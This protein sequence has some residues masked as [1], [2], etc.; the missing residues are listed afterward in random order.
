MNAQ[1]QLYLEI[2]EKLHDGTPLKRGEQVWLLHVLGV[3][4]ADE[5]FFGAKVGRQGRKRDLHFW[6]SMDSMTSG[7]REKV[8]AKRWRQP[9]RIG[10]VLQRWRPEIERRLTEHPTDMSR[11]QWIAVWRQWV[12][13]AH[14]FVSRL[15]VSKLSGPAVQKRTRRKKSTR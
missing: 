3:S 8:V 12:K 7:D 13:F 10:T 15:S 6:M 11:E 2:R 4:G 9:G 14:P 5:F 1:Q